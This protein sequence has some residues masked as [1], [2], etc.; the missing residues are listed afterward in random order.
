MDTGFLSFFHSLLRYAVLIALLFAFIVNLRGMLA[1]RPI[2]VGERTVTILAMVLCHVQLVLGLILYFMNLSAIN[3]MVDPYKR[4][5]KFEHIGGMVVAIALITVGRV[6][7]K[8]AQ[9]ES[10]KQRHIVVFYGIGLLL[11]LVSIPWPFREAFRSLG[12]L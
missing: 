3:Q 8:R 12:W 10:K 2:L 4:F 7:S 6:L 1:K 9:E 11:I 5:W